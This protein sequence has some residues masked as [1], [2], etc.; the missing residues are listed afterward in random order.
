M[1]I[2]R[3]VDTGFWNDDKVMDMFTP[4]DKL[5]MLYLL[6][7]P[8]TTQL[9]V[10]QINKKSMAFEIGYSVEAISVLLDRFES[11]YE[12]IRYSAITKELAIKN[13][14][15][16]S[17]VK[18][19]K[20]VEDLLK[21]EIMQV[22]DKSLLQYVHDG[23]SDLENLNDTV[24][25]IL[26]LLN[27]NQKQNE[28]HNDDDNESE[29]DNDNDVSYHDSSTIR[30]R[31]VNEQTDTRTDEPSEEKKLRVVG[32]V[33]G[34]GVVKLTDEQFDDLLGRLGFDGFNTYVKRLADYIID[35]EAHIR[36]HYQ[37]NLKWYEED[38]EIRG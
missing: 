3:I 15:R 31:F 22:K 13:Y 24:K 34:R 2:K 29:N 36:S 9:G 11:K 30:T 25:K 33:L 8:H 16:H 38:N 27:I 37:T 28:N 18:G 23:I 19:G 12:L 4:E 17:I 6:T 21:K 26:P 5:F 20:P 35:K 10:Y 14:L 7:N 32:G 1:G